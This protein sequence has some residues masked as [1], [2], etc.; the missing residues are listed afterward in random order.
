M[1]MPNFL[2]IGAAKCGTTAL[3]HYLNQHPEVFMSPEKE[4][5]FFALE[6][7][8]PN[9]QGPADARGINRCRYTNLDAYRSLFESV[10]GEKAIG[11]ASTLYLYS[12]K[13][14]ERIAHHVPE[15]R[16]ERGA[17]GAS[18]APDRLFPRRASGRPCSP[19]PLSPPAPC[20]RVLPRL[21][22]ATT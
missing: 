15:A 4:P 12:S 8:T 1:T 14:P 13:A 3:Y 20:S 18:D 7:E 16:R 21:G 5:R 2:I 22:I 10:S 6:G 11:E 9:F 17:S 19:C